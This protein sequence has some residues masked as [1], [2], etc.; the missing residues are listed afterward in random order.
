MSAAGDATT[1]IRRS[2]ERVG[3]AYGLKDLRVSVGTSLLLLR[4]RQGDTDVVDLTTSS[5]TELRLD[6]VSAR[7]WAS[8]ACEPFST[9]GR[10]MGRWLAWVASR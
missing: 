7:V 2:L 8:R 5:A 4:Y 3:R 10:A 1:F 9:V 6:Q